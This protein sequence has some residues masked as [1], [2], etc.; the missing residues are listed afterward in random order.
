MNEF[1][2]ILKQHA[3]EDRDSLSGGKLT[4]LQVNLGDLCNQSCRHCHIEASPKGKNIITRKVI[5]NILTFLSRYKIQTLDITGGAPE[6]NLHFEYFIENA[7]GL[8]DELIVRS[9]LTVLL[10]QDKQHL[11]K[12]N[13]PAVFP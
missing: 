12:Q 13:Q 2:S 1:L 7:R 5:N 10:E 8:V 9:N 11:R 3:L 4:T 6:M